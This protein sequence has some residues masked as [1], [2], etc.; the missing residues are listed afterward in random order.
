MINLLPPKEKEELLL[1]RNKKLVMVLGNT[2]LV[3][4]VCLILILLSLKFY[5]LSEISYQKSN[6]DIAEKN[7]Q[8][9][10]NLSVKDM[11]VGYN[12]SLKKV[13]DFYKKEIYM[14]DAIKD[15]LSVPRS[16]AI[17]FKEI[18]INRSN[19]NKISP[20]KIKVSL[21]GVSNTRNDLIVYKNNIESNKK[22]KN[23][24][25]PPDSWVKNKDVNFYLDFEVLLSEFDNNIEKQ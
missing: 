7:Y 13:D 19:A 8:M 14:S 10:T 12:E 16:G 6:L 24:Y 22:I 25:F 21:Y 4:L 3:V 17:Y 1:Q 18:T 9:P 11:I 23:V 5:I 2:V 15:I 20:E